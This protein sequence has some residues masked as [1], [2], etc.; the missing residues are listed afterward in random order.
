MSTILI[1]LDPTQ[2]ANPDLDIRYLLP[3]AIIERS[4]GLVEDDGYDY[5]QNSPAVYIYLR[6][7][8]LERGLAFTLEVI[9]QIPILD[10]D[11]RAGTEVGVGENGNYRLVYPAGRDELLSI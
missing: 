7:D 3:D 2:L 1:K 11:L 6:T 8:D 10:N 5:S 4:N 9:E